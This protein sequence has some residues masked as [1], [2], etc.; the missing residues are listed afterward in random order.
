MKQMLPAE[1]YGTEAAPDKDWKLQCAE[2]NDAPRFGYRGMHMDVSRHFFDMD[3]VKRYLDIMEV[4]K[5]NTLHWHITDDQGWRIEI[6]KYP[7][8]TEIGS[9]RKRTVVG[10]VSGSSTFDETPYGEGCW[11]SQEQ[12]KEIIAYAAAKGI[13]II[14][15]IDLPGHMLAALAAYPE[16]CFALCPNTGFTIGVKSMVLL[17]LLEDK[18]KVWLRL[19]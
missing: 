8:L 17:Y 10:H 4:H 12:I 9:V 11:F 19:L 7:K 6:K 5:L 13:T 2:I 16:I 18:H 3:M 1:I 15:E 14:P